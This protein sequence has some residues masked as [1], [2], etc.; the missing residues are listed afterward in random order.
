MF[1]CKT[2]TSSTDHLSQD[3]PKL[4]TTTSSPN[5]FEKNDISMENFYGSSSPDISAINQN[6]LFPINLPGLPIPSGPNP[7][8]YINSPAIFHYFDCDG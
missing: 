1:S 8:P 4:Y 6:I 3:G 5:I 2:T 7:S